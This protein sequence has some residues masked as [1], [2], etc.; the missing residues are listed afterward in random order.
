MVSL[1]QKRNPGLCAAWQLQHEQ[2]R[3]PHL[4][5]LAAR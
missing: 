2:S 4:G 3:L 1:G 5:K